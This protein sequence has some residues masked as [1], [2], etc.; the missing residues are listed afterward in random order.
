MKK[1]P[2]IALLAWFVGAGTMEVRAQD[3]ALVVSVGLA[4]MRMD[5][6]KYLLETIMETYPVEA[7]VISIRLCHFRNEGRLF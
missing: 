1:F 2:I 4:D 6:M 3:K 5:D 7:K